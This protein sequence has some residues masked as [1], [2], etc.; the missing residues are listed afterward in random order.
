[1][2]RELGYLRNYG[3]AFF[4]VRQLTHITVNEYQ[5]IA[6]HITEKG[7]YLDGAVIA[8]HAQNSDPVAAAVDQLL[9]PLNDCDTH[10]SLRIARGGFC[11]MSKRFVTPNV[12]AVG[13]HELHQSHPPYGRNGHV[14]SR[15]T[16]PR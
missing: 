5:S 4:T 16:R 13:G 14:D 12:T 6:R 10:G 1:V 9:K 2:E 3:P 7:V 11:S 8:L 15:P